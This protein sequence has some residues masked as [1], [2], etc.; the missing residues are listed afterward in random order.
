MQHSLALCLITSRKDEARARQLA[1]SL[2]EYV[3]ETV[4]TVADKDEKADFKWIDDFSAARNFNFSKAKSDWILWLDADDTL[5]N[6]EKLRDLIKK[7]E[8]NKVSGFWVKYKYAFDEHGNCVDEHWKAQLL[9]NDGHFTWKGAIHEDPIQL[10]NASWVMTTDITRVHHTDKERG[11][12]SFERNIRIL[13]REH[14]K[15][16]NEPRVMFYLGRTYLAS[17][18]YDKCIEI[19]QKYLDK[20]GWDDER[21]EA[22]LL[23]GQAYEQSGDLDTALLAFH[24]AILEKEANPDAYLYKAF[25]L[26]RKGK[27]NEALYNLK[28]AIEL[29]LPQAVTY[30]NPMLY[31]R[32]AYHAIAIAYLHLGKLEDA[33]QAIQIAYQSDS[34][35]EAVI[36]LYG[37]IQA[38]VEKHEAAKQYVK[39]IKYAEKHDPKKVVPILSQIPSPLYDNELIVALRKKF[40]PSKK[41][42]EKSVVVFCGTSAEDWTPENQNKGGIG[43]SETAVIE[44]T[45]RLVK[46]GWKVTVYNQGGHPPEGQ[47]FDG[48]EYKNY[49][50]FNPS[51]KFDV[52]WA[53][54]VPELFDYKMEARLKVL[55]LHDVMN[56]LDFTEDRI[57]E[58]DKIFVKTNYHRSLLPNV[59][60]DKFVIVGNGIDLTRFE[61]KQDKD[62]YRFCYTSSP[63]RG[64]EQLLKMWP[65]IKDALP[66]ATLHVYYGWQTFY[67]LEKNNPERMAWMKK[68]QG[69][70]EQPGVINHGRVGQKELAQDLL[71][72]SYWLY[73]TDFPEIDCITAKEMQAAGVIPI[74]SGYAA[75]EESQQSG[76]KLQGDTY[77]PKWQEEYIKQVINLVNDYAKNKENHRERGH[78]TAGEYSW[79]K[80]TD[81]WEE[82]FSS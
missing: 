50:L 10:K 1:D 25:I 7:A 55:D 16:P 6:P 57:N 9:K 30:F 82:E 46:K 21:Y 53:W 12:E 22:R 60:D 48:V 71:K 78:Q 24:D 4:I 15:D 66:E 26:I 3:D 58:I 56:P 11:K 72:T 19:L 64:L 68:M 79:D 75:L 39:I 45:K 37:A 44:L 8:E 20:S 59:P 5:E 61:G 67:E 18:Q 80:I 63:N 35:N 77:D 43:G 28:Y 14:L 49:W 36:A 65:Q 31:K 32:D 42:P 51:D 52:L 17:L 29:P 76:L 40:V 69:L 41:W 27:H 2:K 73:P 62:P 47:E 13:E 74:T 33:F 81:K 23:I 38:L 34:K 54:R 70:M